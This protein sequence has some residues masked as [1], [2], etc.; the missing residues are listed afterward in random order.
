MGY[1]AGNMSN[2]ALRYGTLNY[3]VLLVV[4]LGQPAWGQESGGLKRIRI[5][6]P[7]RGATTLGLSAAQTYGFFRTQ[8]LYAELI[9]M[10][11]SSRCKL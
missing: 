6:M 10:R 4:C 8:G 7:N 1:N 11:P 2:R 3:F 5:G 9:V